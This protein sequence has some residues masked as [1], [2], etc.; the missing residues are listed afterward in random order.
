[1]TTINERI[2]ALR[3]AMMQEGHSAC[4]IPTGDPHMSENIP[5]H[6]EARRYFS[7][8][9][10]SAGTL[11]VTDKNSGLWVDGRYYTQG[12]EQIAGSEIQLF[13]AVDADC[14]TI[15]QYLRDNLPEG[16]SVCIDGLIESHAS[17]KALAKVLAEKNISLKDSSVVSKVWKDRPALLLEPVYALPLEYSG[18]SAPE[19][20]S[21]LREA[22]KKEG[23]DAILLTR[24]DEIAWLFN[25]RGSDIDCS[26]VFL[27]YAYISQEQA[28]LFTHKNRISPEIMDLLNQMSVSLQE[29]EE[30]FHFLEEIQQPVTLLCD[31]QGTN[32]RLMEL[33]QNNP[34]IT[35]KMQESPI[36]MMKAVKNQVELKNTYEAYILDAM[37]QSEFYG[38]LTEEME[39]GIFYDEYELSCHLQNFR[40]QIKDYLGDSFPAIIGYGSNAAVIHYS[41]EEGTAKQTEP[42]GMLLND[43]GGQYWQGT[44]DTTRTYAMGPLTLQEKRDFTLCLKGVLAL[45]QAVFPEGTTGEQLDV[46]CRQ[47]LW[48]NGLDYRHGTGHGVGHLLNVHEGPHGFGKGANKVPLKEGMTVTIEP[49]YY[50]VGSHG[51]R[52][53]NVVHVVKGQKT[54][55]GQFLHFETFT[56][57][58][59]GTECI[60]V[61]MLTGHEREMLN[62]YHRRVYETIAPRISARAKKWLEEKT[63]AI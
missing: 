58:P 42:R 9:T 62:S 8:F 31:D 48:A 55:Y 50:D 57:M 33:A 61:S 19:K 41:P 6:W 45:T 29:Y 46:L 2:A 11:V 26:P 44:T 3:Q 23:T 36:Q 49:G 59:I 17:C 52:I 35:V 25:L 14:P 56:V 12:A 60:D 5:E 7:G 63:K 13:R 28:V 15:P 16:S 20:L 53:E 51:I 18:C 40:K 10:G 38:W 30:I 54:E 27:S 47:Y 34:V 39:K 21:S 24:L 32:L 37:A 43:S 4:I 22:L 1:M